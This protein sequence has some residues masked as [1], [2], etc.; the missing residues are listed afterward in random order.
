M[1]TL[2]VEANRS[3]NMQFD[4]NICCNDLHILS[5]VF[6]V[7]NQTGR[8]ETLTIRQILYVYWTNLQDDSRASHSEENGRRVYMI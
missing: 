4:L 7:T 1:L 8:D 3:S 2:V 5:I 6:S